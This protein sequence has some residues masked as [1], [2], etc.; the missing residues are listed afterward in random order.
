MEDVASEEEE[1]EEE[2][3]KKK[4]KGKKLK[5]DSDSEGEDL[6]GDA[7]EADYK[8]NPELDTYEE[9]VVANNDEEAEPLDFDTRLAAEK[10]M[11][12]RDRQLAEFLQGPTGQQDS[13][14]DEDSEENQHKKRRLQ[15]RVEESRAISGEFQIR[16]IENV[17][18]LIFLLFKICKWEMS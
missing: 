12:V 5:G 2:V 13:D 11:D 9:D 17:V 15:Q 6:F 18:I 10:A 1:L 14:D 3:E 4:K 16:G 8:A 7:L